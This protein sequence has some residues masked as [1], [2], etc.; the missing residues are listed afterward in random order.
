VADAPA[1]LEP[2]DVRHADVEDD[3]VGQLQGEL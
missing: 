3:R 1:D 2:V